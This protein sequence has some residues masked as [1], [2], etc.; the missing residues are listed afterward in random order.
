M[1]GRVPLCLF[2]LQSLRRSGDA[3]LILVKGEVI[4]VDKYAAQM[5]QARQAGEEVGLL[6]R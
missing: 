5:D 1:Y 6:S 2:L 4:A 3:L